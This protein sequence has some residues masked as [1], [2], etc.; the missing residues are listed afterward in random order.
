MSKPLS[1][2]KAVWDGYENSSSSINI[3]HQHA[4]ENVVREVI[5]TGIGVDSSVSSKAVWPFVIR[6]L[7]ISA[8]RRTY[9]D[10]LTHASQTA[11]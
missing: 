3:I 1:Q 11:N 10:A 4:A 6:M 9:T 5:E 2:R 8:K 7:A